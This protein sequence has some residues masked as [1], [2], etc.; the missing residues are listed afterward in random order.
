M[1][2]CLS[3][4]IKH[5]Q[6]VLP[7]IIVILSFVVDI[8]CQSGDH[9]TIWTDIENLLSLDHIFKKRPIITS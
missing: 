5:S 4:S 3:V 2:F 7:D 9:K 6:S 8:S 1:L